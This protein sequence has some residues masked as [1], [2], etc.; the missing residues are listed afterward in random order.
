[1]KGKA[2]EAERLRLHDRLAAFEDFESEILPAL[3]KDLKAGMTP[4]QLRQKYD[5][6]V[7]ARAITTALTERDSGKAMTAVKDILDRTHGKATEKKEVTHRFKDM[8]DKELDAVIK[9][10]EAELSDMEERFEQ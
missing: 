9:S 1:M 6:I 10:E 7:Q 3:I 8:S 2:A 4:D 5:S